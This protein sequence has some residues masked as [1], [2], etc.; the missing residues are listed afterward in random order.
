VSPR[1]LQ[2]LSVAAIVVASGLISAGTTLGVDYS[3]PSVVGQNVAGPSV[4]ALARL[5]FKAFVAEQPIM[6]TVSLV[7]RAPFVALAGVFGGGMLLEYR[8]GSFACVVALGLLALVL[9]QRIEGE[10]PWPARVLTAGL[11]LAGPM[12]F[13]ALFWGHPEEL[14]AAALAVGAVLVAGRRPVIAAIMLGS[15]IATKQWAILAIVPVL[16]TAA[17]QYRLRLLF[18]A[19]ALAALWFAPMAIGDFERFMAQNKANGS[20]G[21]GVTPTSVWWVFGDVV[22][23][24]PGLKG[25]EQVDIHALPHVLSKL[26]EPLA[27][28]ATF[29][30][31]ILFWFRR[32]SFE[33][34]DALTLLA[35]LMLVRC[36]LDPLAISYHHL[37][38]Y[39]A[40]AAAEVVRTRHLPV[41]TL[42]TAGVLLLTSELAGM[43]N[44][45]NAVYLA[46][47]VPLATYLGL[48]LFAPRVLEALRLRS[49]P[50]H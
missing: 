28:G 26:S 29:G 32:R 13:K 18:G 37:P 5:D 22:G 10:N 6:G 49:A 45:Q 24:Q 36:V 11:V 38:F 14:L 41:L 27:I 43:P 47:T 50:A 44:L 3:N 40:L 1:A 25:E 30:L 16:V 48:S 39:V 19:G 20:S 35:L 9:A 23:S 17:P 34:A 7:L 4:E 46:W 8:L 12:T 42:V 21:P 2:L 15:A 33:L 31:S